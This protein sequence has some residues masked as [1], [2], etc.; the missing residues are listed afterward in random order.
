LVVPKTKLL[1]GVLLTLLFVVGSI[2]I[3]YSGSG[4]SLRA[5]GALTTQVIA[6]F[7][8]LQMCNRPID[9]LSPAVVFFVTFEIFIA[10]GAIALSVNSELLINYISVGQTLQHDL[11]RYMM[12]M[13]L[14][15]LLFAVSVFCCRIFFE[16]VNGLEL[17]ATNGATFSL[18]LRRYSNWIILGYIACIAVALIRFYL[19][20]NIIDMFQGVFSADYTAASLRVQLTQDQY[21]GGTYF[22]QGYFNFIIYNV[23]PFFSLLVF[24]LMEDSK[25]NFL[26]Y[27]VLVVAMAFLFAEVRRG[28]VVQFL[29]AIFVLKALMGARV[30]IVR[31]VQAGVA[32]FA[33]LAFASL[34]LGRSPD[35][36]VVG[37]LAYR[38][39]ISQTQTGTYIFQIYP[40][41]QDFAFGK[42]YL[43]NL[44]G[45]LPGADEGHAT[46]LFQFI[47]GRV[48]GASHS[49]VVEA[50]ANFS[51]LGSLAYVALL[52]F[53]FSRGKLKM[54]SARSE[55]KPLEVV[56]YAVFLAYIIP[57]ITNGGIM[58]A[59][60][61]VIGLWACVWIIRVGH[62]IVFERK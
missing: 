42:I 9:L 13:S 36:S 56:Y 38:I 4:S 15:S 57:A 16:P 28:P 26:K 43:D 33:M 44:S 19:Q 51:Y 1:G 22:G 27:F 61:H 25:R 8:I 45:I 37:A 46:R 14:S 2:V 29:I 49:S 34:I 47:H 3:G 53:F 23:L 48:G 60:L 50:Y 54:A 6:G 52:G 58:G 41:I 5:V 12:V 21:G 40:A 10:I 11:E 55:N 24:L 31:V 39:F 7:I 30:S 59:L 35:I 32:V 18:N 20:A 62:Q 17:E